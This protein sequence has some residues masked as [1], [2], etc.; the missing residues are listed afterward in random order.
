M[1]ATAAP[2]VFTPEASGL[3]TSGALAGSP[4]RG[5]W[6]RLLS[7][8]VAVVSPTRL[9]RVAIAAAVAVV[10]TLLPPGTAAVLGAATA[11]LLS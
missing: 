5:W 8:M 4:A 7:Q 3:P 9:S 11:A 6:G 2:A 10:V 1:P